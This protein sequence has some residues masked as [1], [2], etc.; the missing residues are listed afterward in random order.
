MYA[1]K[2]GLS[3]G[4]LW[5]MKKGWIKDASPAVGE[6]VDAAEEKVKKGY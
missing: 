5:Q 2:H 1:R 3:V 6:L 4:D